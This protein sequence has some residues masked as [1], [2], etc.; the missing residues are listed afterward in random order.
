[1]AVSDQLQRPLRDLRV[2]VTDR[3]NFRC[4]YCMPR[5]AFG[6]DFRFLDRAELLTF[7]EVTR[8]AR[9]FARLGVRKLRITGGEPLVRRGVERLVG[10]VASLDGIVEVAMTT[11]ASLLP[12]K[13]EALREAG[14]GRI[15]VS[16]DSLDD[17]TFRAMSD[18]NLPVKVVLDGIAAAREA[19]FAPIKINT[20]VKRG[21]NDTG[22]LALARFGR[23]QGHIVR[24][25][26]YM[27]VGTTNGWRLTDV[28]PAEDIV[29]RISAVFPLEPVPASS[30]GEVA[31][32]YR[33]RDGGGE[34]GVIASVTRPFCQ[35]CTRARLSATGELYTCLFAP[36]GHD[37]RALV[38]SGG[39]DDEL[40]AFIQRTWRGRTDR[41]SEL[42]TAGR[43]LPKVEMSYIGG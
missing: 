27:D 12:H 7:E 42:R 9:V 28:V 23:E 18:A 41:Y 37:L 21:V 30:P 22:I 15:T 2:S 11:N 36:S 5:E 6:A 1:M 40:E 31:T 43:K 16:L 33:Y 3:C 8:I 25:I 29:A 24:F 13:A 4:R 34:I 32:G 14:L 35:T 39:S 19:G 38:R 26:E 20:V 10:M 17:V